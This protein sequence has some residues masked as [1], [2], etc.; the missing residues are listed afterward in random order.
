MMLLS[1]RVKKISLI[2]V[3]CHP[4]NDFTAWKSVRYTKLIC[5]LGKLHVLASYVKNGDPHNF[6]LILENITIL[7]EV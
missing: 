5:T 6:D 3:I 2:L 4:Y 7:V 1:Q